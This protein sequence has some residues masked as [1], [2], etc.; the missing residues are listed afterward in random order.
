MY[1]NDSHSP[2]WAGESGTGPSQPSG[3]VVRSIFL[4]RPGHA[5]FSCQWHRRW[6]VADILPIFRTGMSPCWCSWKLLAKLLERLPSR[7]LRRGMG[8][9]D[10]ALRHRSRSSCPA[11]L[12]HSERKLVLLQI[13][14][15]RWGYLLVVR[16]RTQLRYMEDQMNSSTWWNE[17]FICNSANLLDNWKGPK[18]LEGQFVVRAVKQR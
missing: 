4:F 5:F 14:R 11:A 9:L 15:K 8:P 12:Q 6:Q 7:Q 17:Q 10:Q 13:R 18:K 3:P 16:R 2:H 1:Y